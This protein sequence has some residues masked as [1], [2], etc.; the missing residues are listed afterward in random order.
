LYITES[1]L[2]LKM[3]LSKMPKW[4]AKGPFECIFGHC[5]PP[6]HFL[7]HHPFLPPLHLAHSKARGTLVFLFFLATNWIPKWTDQKRGFKSKSSTLF[8]SIFKCMWLEERYIFE[9][10]LHIMGRG[11]G[12]TSLKSPPEKLTFPNDKMFRHAH[13]F[14]DRLFHLDPMTLRRGGE[15]W[16]GHQIALR[17]I[18]FSSAASFLCVLSC[19][20]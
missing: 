6:G 9:W 20:L 16:L 1:I 11:G 4:R 14:I 2:P 7:P 15:G 3:P 17:L 10:T 12:W 13:S 8:L 5:K 19:F 18:E